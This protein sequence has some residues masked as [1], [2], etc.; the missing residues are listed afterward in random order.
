M[1]YLSINHYVGVEWYLTLRVMRFV[2]VSNMNVWLASIISVA[3][4]VTRP[5]IVS[6]PRIKTR[7]FFLIKNG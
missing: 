7:E 6:A 5:G 1:K 2:L 4:L 3:K